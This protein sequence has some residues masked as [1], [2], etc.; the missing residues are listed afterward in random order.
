MSTTVCA[1]LL[2]VLDDQHGLGAAGRR[3]ELDIGLDVLETFRARQVDPHGRAL[4]GLAVD[5]DVAAG[6]LDE[7]VDHAEPEAGALAL[8]LGG[9]ERLEDVVDDLGGMPQPVSVTAIITYWPGVT[10]AWRAA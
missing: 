3:T 6:L 5:L 1:H 10:S 2:V 7:A 8:G 4:A 9:E